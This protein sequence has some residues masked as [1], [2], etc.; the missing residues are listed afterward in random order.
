MRSMLEFAQAKGCLTRRLLTHFGEAMDADCGHCGPC[1]DE[2][3]RPV[4]AP[5]VRHLGLAEW[6]LVARLRSEG[7]AALASPA[8][9]RPVSVRAHLAGHDAAPSS[10]RTADSA[11][12]PTSRSGM[13]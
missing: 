8:A 12:W 10:R 2:P 1:L 6:D 9:A 4:P 13:S 3:P 11:S 7:H 5:T